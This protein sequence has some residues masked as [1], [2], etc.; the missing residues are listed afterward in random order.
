MLLVLND[1]IDNDESMII[2]NCSSMHRNLPLVKQLLLDPT[3]TL[4][5]FPSDFEDILEGHG[6]Q[7]LIENTRFS[8]LALI[9]HILNAF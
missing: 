2:K 1:N 8:Q 3:S 5:V 9:H 7:F 4:Y 6:I